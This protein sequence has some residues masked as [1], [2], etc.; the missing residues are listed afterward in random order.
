MLRLRLGRVVLRL[1]TGG[2]LPRVKLGREGEP[3][4]RIVESC[5][6]IIIIPGREVE[7]VSA[8]LCDLNTA[9]LLF[10]SPAPCPALSLECSLS[11]TDLARPETWTSRIIDLTFGENARI[12]DQNV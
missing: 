8:W 6:E 4:E 11:T 1:D 12:R 2:E 9:E 7:E 3:E 10:L 5:P